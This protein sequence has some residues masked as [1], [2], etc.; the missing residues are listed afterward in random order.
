M[1]KTYPL[2][3]AMRKFVEIS[4]DCFPDEVIKAGIDSQ[5][6]A[7]VAMNQQF[8][9]T[10]PPDIDYRDEF[11]HWNEEQVSVRRYQS[12]HTLPS[13]RI[14]FVHG[15]GWYLGNLDSH[16]FFAAK[17]AYDCQSELVSVDYRLAPEHPYPAALEDVY[18]VYR[19]MLEEAPE[20][21]PPLLVGDSAGANLIAALS[22][23]CRDEGLLPAMGQILIYPGLA[24]TGTLASHQQ[25]SNAPLLNTAAIEFCWR[26]YQ[27]N[28]MT[29]LNATQQS[30]LLPLEAED[31]SG[32]PPARL[33]P[34]E[35]DPLKD[36]AVEYARRIK[37]V[38]GDADLTLGEGLVHGCLRAI[39]SAAEADQFYQSICAGCAELFVASDNS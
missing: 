33:Y 32:L 10:H 19:A 30:Y 22:L 18:A 2:S 25:C 31:F 34:V 35:F 16:D 1:R 14:L 3:E 8:D 38:G 23:R 11:L 20:K 7:Y 12:R 9:I 37:R 26:M 36:D 13:R 15:G 17:L 39:G 21:T 24:R 28:N 27:P 6:K 29:L 4:E 5:R